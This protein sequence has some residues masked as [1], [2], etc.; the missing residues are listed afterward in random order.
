M[1]IAA[2]LAALALASTGCRTAPT[3]APAP[4]PVEA[5][6]AKVALV[7]GGGAARGFAHVGV[8]RALE[9][10]KIPIDLIVGTSVGSLI[11]AIYAS[12]LNSFD[13]EWT[14]FSLQ[15]DDLLDYGVLTAVLG[16]GL[17]KGDKLE[18]FVRSKVATHA[19][20]TLGSPWASRLSRYRCR[21]RA[22]STV[23]DAATSTQHSSANRAALA[24]R[25]AS[26]AAAIRVGAPK[27]TAVERSADRKSVV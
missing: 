21:R 8:I 22:T 10:E 27:P 14:A 4:P 12:D 23:T 19:P 20:G 9:Q 6:R 13:L 24:A 16:M 11:G 7:L 2:L 26:R 25:T 5:P 3:P 15:K 18:S 1:R 17:A